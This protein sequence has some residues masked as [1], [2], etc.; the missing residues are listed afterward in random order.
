MYSL[1]LSAICHLEV[2]VTFAIIS[3]VSTVDSAAVP[4]KVDLVSEPFT[5]SRDDTVKCYFFTCYVSVSMPLHVCV[6]L[7]SMCTYVHVCTGHLPMCARVQVHSVSA[8]ITYLLTFIIILLH[9]FYGNSLHV[10][11]MLSLP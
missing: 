6:H 2:G 8:C 1:I 5:H 10:Y 9:L 4:Q 7:C 11:A 3:A